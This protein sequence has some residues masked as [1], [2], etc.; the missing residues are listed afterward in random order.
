M[1][2]KYDYLIVGTGLFG[3]V[4]AR[5]L[6][7]VGLKC[8]VIDKKKHI[9]GNCYTENV[10]GIN[11]HK[12]GPH[13]FHTNDLPVL[14]YVK[15]HT[16]INNFTCRPK[17]K[18]GD[19]VY[20]FPINLMTLN[21]LWGVTTPQEA[22]NKIDE[23]T[24]EYKKLYPNPKNSYEWG[25][26]NVGEEIFNIFY[27]PYLRKQWNK[28]PKD[29]PA[30]VLMR[31]VIR[32][33]YNDSYY[34]DT[35][36]GILDYTK[37]FDNLLSGIDV[38]L[39][40]DYLNNKE[41]LDNVFSKK[42]VYSG[43]IDEFYDYK[44]GTLEYRSL[45]FETERLE[46]KDY[47]GVFMVSYPE[48][49]YKFTRIIEHKHFDF[50][51]QDFTIITREYSDDWEIG[52][53]AYYPINDDTNQIIYSEYEKYA[54]KDSDKIIFGGRLGSYK[55]LNMDQTIKIALEVSE[56]IKSENGL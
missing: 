28:D 27:G 6:T 35:H 51:D 48:E 21:Q 4:I 11:I 18:F 31:Q 20:S 14:E 2:D 43:P 23:V 32:F 29:I 41:Q 52:K 33:D 8:L 3:S 30:F 56:K 54:I 9:G 37:L 46:M 16:T 44:F 12:Y 45:R 50:G 5:E 36:Q 7:D 22:R 26:C 39:D 17:L 1:K 25:M 15:K 10:D 34:Y 53:T 47:Q 38:V 42:M 55:Y 40:I 13:I 24:K 19:N 49:K